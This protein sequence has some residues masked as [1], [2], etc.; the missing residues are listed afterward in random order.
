MKKIILILAATFLIGA[1][2]TS[3]KKEKQIEP[4]TVEVVK[5]H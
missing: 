5:K 4:Q 1:T 2:L 3:C